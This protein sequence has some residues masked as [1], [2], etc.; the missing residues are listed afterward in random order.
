MASRNKHNLIV[1]LTI[2]FPMKA[3]GKEAAAMRHH[4]EATMVVIRAPGSPVLK[5]VWMAAG[6]SS[7]NKADVALES[8]LVVVILASMNM[9]VVTPIVVR[10]ARP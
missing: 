8:T 3:I 4:K 1:S 9:L 7:P 10:S 2:G 5:T 6:T